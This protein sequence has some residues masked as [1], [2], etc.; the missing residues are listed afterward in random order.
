MCS[1]LVN[2]IF[3]SFTLLQLRVDICD[4]LVDS[5]HLNEHHVGF[6]LLRSQLQLKTPHM[7]L[8]LAGCLLLLVL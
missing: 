5:A 3:C 4:L 2:L 7:V 8:M 1:G 6:G